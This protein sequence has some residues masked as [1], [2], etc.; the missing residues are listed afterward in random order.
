MFKRR[1]G[2]KTRIP[3]LVYELKAVHDGTTFDFGITTIIDET[4]NHLIT[5][6][7]RLKNKKEFDIYG[8]FKPSL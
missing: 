5:V 3:Y 7:P 1:N 6:T 4:N 2:E 8:Y